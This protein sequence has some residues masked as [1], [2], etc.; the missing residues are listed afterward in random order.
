[1]RF[2]YHCKQVAGH[3]GVRLPGRQTYRKLKSGCYFKR[4]SDKTI[5]YFYITLTLHNL[6]MCKIYDTLREDIYLRSDRKLLVRKRTL[7]ILWD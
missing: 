6:D 3:P 5:L 2:P 7:V 4:L 1:M